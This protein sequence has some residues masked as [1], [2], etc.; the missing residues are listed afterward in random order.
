VPSTSFSRL[1][2]QNP[3]D[4]PTV[5]VL[6]CGE[7]R[8][9]LRALLVDHSH[10][11]VAFRAAIPVGRIVAHSYRFVDRT[12]TADSVPPDEHSVSPLSVGRTDELELLFSPFRNAAPRWRTHTYQP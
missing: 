3:S 8:P 10:L 4:T 6:L 7:M 1:S 2:L 11:Q 9:T 5:D 12:D